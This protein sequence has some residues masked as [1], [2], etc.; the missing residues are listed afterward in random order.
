MKLKNLFLILLILVTGSLNNHV[1]HAESLDLACEKYRNLKCGDF[2][3]IRR[4]DL[5]DEFSD[6][7][8]KT[9][10]EF[11]KK[12]YNLSYECL[13]YFDYIT[14]EIIRCAMGKLDGVDL[15]FDINE[16]EGYNVASL[17][18]HP[19]GIFSPPSGKNFGILGRA[20]EDYE[21]I[22][23]R[24]GFWI[25]KAKRL[26]LDLMQE[27]NFVSDALFYHSL[28]KCSNRYH[29]EEILDK[30]IDIRYGNQL[31]KYINDK[32]LSNIQLTK[33]EYV[34]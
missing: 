8:F 17:H 2:P 13:I 30:M 28:Q 22:T 15:T 4:Q 34:K 7:A 11:I 6:L 20:F 19:E 12:T 18:N 24:D 1:V 16:F 33:K 10:D 25:F 26:D 3:S 32:N 9:I 27:L 31:L 21:L 29:D 5:P 23:S 14:G